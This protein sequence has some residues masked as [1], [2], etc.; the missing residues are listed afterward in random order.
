MRRLAVALAAAVVLFGAG[1]WLALEGQEV[2][3]LHTA[4]GGTRLWPVEDAAG[5]TWIEA[6]NP[7]RSFYRDLRASPDVTLERGGVV[8]PYRAVPVE[9]PEAHERV[10]R[11]LAAKYGFADRWIGILVDTSRSVAIRLEPR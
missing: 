4:S 1:T 9:T 8:R 11:L 7:E 6:G 10:R 2:A 3:V 5:T